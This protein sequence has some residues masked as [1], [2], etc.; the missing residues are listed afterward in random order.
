MLE[1]YGIVDEPAIVIAQRDILA[2]TGLR[3][4]DIPG[5]KI[6][7]EL[8]GIRTF[9]L[10]LALHG[11]IPHGYAV[12]QS[13][14]FALRVAKMGRNKHVIVDRERRDPICDRGVEER[15]LTNVW[16]DSDLKRHL[17]SWVTQG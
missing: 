4:S 14:V 10:N 11:N 3:I 7:C 17:N 8:A 13:I 6:L 2:L 1:Q 12:Y 15:R 16:T 9:E 5:R